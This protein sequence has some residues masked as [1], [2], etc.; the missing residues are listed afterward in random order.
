M[1]V[2]NT[3]PIQHFTANG[4]SKVFTVNFAVENKENL[5]VTVNGT[6]VSVNDY[7]YD[8][9]TKAVVFN[10]APANGVEV[11]IERI[12][13]LERSIN[14]QTY[15]NSFRPETL[16]YDLD[17]IW[18]VL[19]EQNIVDAEILARL[20][21]EID[22]RIAHDN[23][24]LSNINSE[25]DQR[26][27]IDERVRDEIAQEVEARRTL[28]LNYDTLA[29]VRDLQVFGALK[30]YL[31]TIIASTS[32][33]VFGGV[34]AGIVF[35]LDKKSVQ[36]HLEDIYQKLLED[37]EEI[38]TKADQSYVDQK[39]STKANK[40][41]VYEKTEVFTKLEVTNQVSL[42]ADKTYVNDALQAL[43]NG[44]YKAYPTLGAANADIAN[45]GLNTK[46]EVLNQTNG[47]SY[48]KATENA[49]SL[50][51]S[52]YDPLE[53]A[54]TF[55]TQAI[56]TANKAKQDFIIPGELTKI[57]IDPYLQIGSVNAITGVLEGENHVNRRSIVHYPVEQGKVYFISNNA[58][59]TSNLRIA[60]F[61]ESNNLLSITTKSNSQ[62]THLFLT[63][64]VNAVSVS[65]GIKSGNTDSIVFDPLTVDFYSAPNANLSL[66]TINQWDLQDK[67]VPVIQDNISS[68]NATVEDLNDIV[69]GKQIYS[70]W[71]EFGLGSTGVLN[72]YPYES[73]SEY[74]EVEDGNL[75]T[76]DQPM[77]RINLY[78]SSKTFITQGG[79][80][81]GT[82]FIIPEGLGVAYIRISC[83]KPYD[84]NPIIVTILSKENAV[85]KLTQKVKVLE[86]EKQQKI[87][88]NGVQ[89]IEF[90]DYL[91]NGAIG[92]NG[93]IEAHDRRKSIVKMPIQQDL[94]YV[95]RNKAD[96]LSNLRVAWFSK[97]LTVL[98]TKYIAP[99]G[100]QNWVF[101]S[102]ADAAYVSITLKSGNT[103]TISL[104]E[105]NDVEI[106]SSLTGFKLSQVNG[107]DV[108]GTEV[109]DLA[110]QLSSLK[111][112]TTSLESDAVKNVS[113]GGTYATKS[114]NIVTIESATAQRSGLMSATDKAK[115]DALV[116]GTITI[117]GSGVAKNA[118]SFGFIPTNNADQN[119]TALKAAVAGG[120][121][122]L[123]DYPG[124]YDINQ[125]IPLESN[126]ELVFGS[127]VYINKVLYNGKSPRYTFINKGAYTKEWDENI[128]IRGLKIKCNGIGNGG[129]DSIS[130]AGLRGHVAMFY[131]RNFHLDNFELLD[132]DATS[133][134]VHICTFENI[135]ITGSRIE[136][137]KDA[138]HLGNGKTFLIRDGQFRTYDDPIALNA[139]DYATGQPELGW[140]ENG[141]IE[142]CYDLADPV[143][144]TTGYFARI[145]AGAW[146]DWFS[147]MQVQQSDTVV[148]SNGKMYR[149]SNGVG[150]TTVY[151]TSTTEPSHASGT[152]EVNGIK[153]T[154]CQENGITHTV[155]VR[156]VKFKDIFLQK[157]RPTALSIHFDTGRF[158][159]SYY[160]N[161]E[162]P[163]QENITFEGLH[164]QANI[165]TLVSAITPLKNL[166]I[167][168][169]EIGE[170]KIV[171][172]NV[173][174]AGM[175]YQ[176]VNIL[177]LGNTFTGVKNHN[178]IECDTGRT[179]KVK[180]LGSIKEN[181]SYLPTFGTGTTILQSDLES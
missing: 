59:T 176:P 29:Q 23:Q 20:K 73:H 146:V 102:V 45:I 69:L 22:W 178:L 138:V 51:K 170:S 125:S 127:K 40:T 133:Y 57:D 12:T 140:V 121:T 155:G 172:K 62:M 141:L 112:R 50:T 17:R 66:S 80:L 70:T 33:N 181:D 87:V 65:I 109:G 118:A 6:T 3:N 16:N 67:R 72:S 120:G 85:T 145:L 128:I 159:R 54:N 107:W 147:G 27:L 124:V 144:G 32:P 77:Y 36:T 26:R 158:S 166:K 148:A 142:N 156:N 56:K 152:V 95:V 88:P 43:N 48:Y 130:I 18:R 76:S 15:N 100:M 97:D 116:N 99:G 34:T 167:I 8:A 63:A 78:S 60:W 108:A 55:T 90:K 31:D 64:P 154:M 149:V 139:H 161:A 30:D 61:D 132:G 177:M 175:S 91:Q 24:I 134:V 71:L 113:V 111:T 13:S 137:Y 38:E 122:V 180:I 105:I 9:S 21:D 136:G 46:V 143:R 106:Y 75:I 96:T 129:D 35:A 41:D 52:P 82:S 58:D 74:I 94:Q 4:Q 153:W 173:N 81:G 151:Y 84:N 42:K 1:T 115:L 2:E 150:E 164:I 44:S 93:E 49:T 162:I 157:D 98:S 14:Y 5:K 103:D 101:D 160:P 179:A 39:L 110:T 79:F 171:L 92:T 131:I 165:P 37:R 83:N 11:V 119:V 168:N 7:S 10:T 89:V 117:N 174:T 86:K 104:F 47:G 114:N 25:A 53:A 135:K 19:Q 28:D 163:I 169:S 68:L 126:T 123:I